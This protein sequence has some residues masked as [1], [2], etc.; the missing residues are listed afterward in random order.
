MFDPRVGMY[1]SSFSQF[2]C[3]EY[4]NSVS[5]FVI[6]WRG[7]AERLSETIPEWMTSGAGHFLVS[8]YLLLF[9]KEYEAPVPSGY[10]LS[11]GC[12]SLDFSTE[13]MNSYSS[14]KTWL[15]QP[16]LCEFLI[17]ALHGVGPTL[18]CVGLHVSPS[19]GSQNCM[20]LSL[21]PPSDG[22]EMHS[23]S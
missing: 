6:S 2:F 10:E 20:Q 4:F 15:K 19:E 13:L 3:V 11:L 21:W 1:H 12:P 17:L 8:K 23:A 16:F 22:L 14:F 18:L 9:Q 7:R 5:C